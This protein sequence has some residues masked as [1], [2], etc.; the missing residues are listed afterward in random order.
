MYNYIFILKVTYISPYVLSIVG[1]CHYNK[2]INNI[3]N[4]LLKT[5]M[6]TQ[7]HQYVL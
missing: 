7:P 1:A 5:H 2:W 3:N 6:S 4:L